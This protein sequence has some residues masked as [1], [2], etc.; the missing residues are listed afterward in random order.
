MGTD[1][2]SPNLVIAAAILVTGTCF[3]G[4]DSSAATGAVSDAFATSGYERAEVC[5]IALRIPTVAAF[6]PRTPLGRRLW[7]A[8]RRIVESGRGLVPASEILAEIERS[9]G[10]DA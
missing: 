6:E 9:R 5:P 10:Q 1:T 8:R 2:T 3:A 7:E 4:R